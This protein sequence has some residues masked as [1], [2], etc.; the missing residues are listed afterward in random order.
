MRLQRDLDQSGVFLVKQF[1]PDDT[2]GKTTFASMTFT[3]SYHAL[4]KH[5]YYPDY[6][7]G[8]STFFDGKTMMESIQACLDKPDTMTADAQRTRLEKDFNFS[9]GYKGY[10][11]GES[12]RI[13]VVCRKFQNHV[14]TAYPI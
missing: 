2:T 6:F 11:K 1:Y 8:A 3:V 12:F 9:I 5:L 14:I 4:E 10:G 13:K 7:K